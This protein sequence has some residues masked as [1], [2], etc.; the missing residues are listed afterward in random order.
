MLAGSPIPD[1]AI[2]NAEDQATSL[3]THVTAS[4]TVAEDPANGGAEPTTKTYALLPSVSTVTATTTKSRSTI[5]QIYPIT[6]GR[7]T[8]SGPTS[9]FTSIST[10]IPTNG[11]TG[12]GPIVIIATDSEGSTRTST[13]TQAGAVSTYTTTDSQGST[14]TQTSVLAAIASLPGHSPISSSSVVSEILS[15]TTTTVAPVKTH[16][17]VSTSSKIPKAPNADETNSSPFK[18]TNGTASRPRG[19]SLGLCIALS[20]LYVWL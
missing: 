19:G 7:T 9:T 6:I 3:A 5:Y 14:M 13:S 18:N 16:S 17:I 8:I 2:Q 12:V 11:L 10:P 20:V 1:S 4:L 15:F